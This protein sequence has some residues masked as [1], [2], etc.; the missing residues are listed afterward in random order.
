MPNK[1]ILIPILLI[2]F[3]LRL[4]QVGGFRPSSNPSHTDPL[5]GLRLNFT[6]Q[7]YSYAPGDSGALIAGM[8]LGD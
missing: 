7:I 6:D 8:L 3:G 4:I 2:L 1:A 5:H